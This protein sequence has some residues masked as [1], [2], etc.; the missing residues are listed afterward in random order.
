MVLNL[1]ASFSQ[2]KDVSCEISS[3]NTE[4]LNPCV[5]PSRRMAGG[6]SLL[7]LAVPLLDG[8]IMVVQ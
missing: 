3:H 4:G 2:K 7:V 8:R 6:N 1:W 5:S